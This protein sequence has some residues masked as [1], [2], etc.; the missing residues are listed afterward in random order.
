MRGAIGDHKVGRNHRVMKAV[1]PM[2]IAL[3]GGTWGVTAL[4]QGYP[5]KPIKLIVPF[6]PGG[7]VDILSRISAQE[8]S[9]GLGQ[10]IV[11]ENRGGAGGTIGT[12][13]AANAPS[14]GYTIVLGTSGALT[15]APSLY[16]KV[17]Y[18]PENSFAPIS[19]LAIGAYIVFVS[20]AVPASSLKELI[21]LARSKPSQLNY[22]S[23]GFGSPLHIAGEMFKSV[24]K[25]DLVHVPFKGGAEAT[26]ALFTGQV[27]VIINVFA[28]AGQYV[29]AGKLRAL[30]VASSRRHPLLPDVPTAAEAGLPGFEVNSWFGV[31]APRGTPND[32]IKRLNAEVLKALATKEM[33]NTIVNQGFEPAGSSP[34]EFSAFIRED[35]AKWSRVI[36]ATGARIE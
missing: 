31:L 25:L 8:L 18:D 24:A 22:G 9:E 15:M 12:K 5:T 32:V 20:P 21:N 13:A 34:E 2:I 35:Y 4:A 7:P 23:A 30:A 27:Q 6:T 17:G 26:V 3:L 14:D 19:L 10:P 11:V 16:P 36:K 29:Q 28:P 1:L 33:R